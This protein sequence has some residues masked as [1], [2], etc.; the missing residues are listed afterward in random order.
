MLILIKIVF[1][2][3]FFKDLQKIAVFILLFSIIAK[4]LYVS[5]IYGN[6]FLDVDGF[7]KK[8]CVNK[9]KVELKCNG[10]CELAKQLNSSTETT[11]TKDQAIINA[12]DS[13]VVVYYKAFA[14]P[15]LQAIFSPVKKQKI[16]TF[17]QFKIQSFFPPIDHPPEVL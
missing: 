7:I 12:S 17:S 1:L 8:Y 5:S 9:K 3:K 14:E 15:L 2:L 10:K 11:P 4:P 13:F 16:L 6:Y